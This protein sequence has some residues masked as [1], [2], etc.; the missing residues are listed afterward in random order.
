MNMESLE[1]IRALP[2]KEQLAYLLQLDQSSLTE[3]EADGYRSLYKEARL[4]FAKAQ[5]Y[6]ICMGLAKWEERQLDEEIREWLK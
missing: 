4:D 1:W 5:S 6:N 2:L 3:K